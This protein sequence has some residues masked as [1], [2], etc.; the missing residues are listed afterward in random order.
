M[1]CVGVDGSGCERFGAHLPCPAPLPS[2]IRGQYIGTWL[3][4]EGF[5]GAYVVGHDFSPMSS[6]HAN[7]Q[8]QPQPQASQ[9]MLRGLLRWR[10]AFPT[11]FR[12]PPG[13]VSL[14][15]GHTHAPATPGLWAAPARCWTDGPATQVTHIHETLLAGG[16]SPGIDSKRPVVKKEGAAGP[17]GL[18]GGPPPNILPPAAEQHIATKVE[19]EDAALIFEYA[20]SNLLKKHGLTGLIFPKE[21][22]WLAG[23]PGS[24]KGTMATS[25]AAARDLPGIIEVSSLLDAEHAEKKR[26]GLLVDDRV[27]LETVL[28]KMMDDKFIDGGGVV[29]DGF[30]RTMV[31]ALTIKLLFDQMKILRDIHINDPVLKN[32]FRRPFFRIVCLYVEEEESIRRQLRRGAEVKRNNEIVRLSGLGT[33]KP[34]RDTD[35]SEEKARE[36]YKVFKT[37]VYAALKEIKPHFHFSFIKADGPPEEVIRLIKEEFTYQSS[38]DLGD[39]TFELVRGIPT[40]DQITKLSRPAMV[41][42]LNMFARDDAGLFNEIVQLIHRDFLHIISR[43]SLA[44]KAIIRSSSALLERNNA[45]NILLDVLSERGYS[46]TLEVQRISVPHLISPP[47]PDGR[48]EITCR[49][50]KSWVFT[51]KFPKPQIRRSTHSD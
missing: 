27:V 2:S 4:P 15:A 7:P 21:V 33:Y 12:I 8:L 49:I 14:T 42:R 41:Q 20:W 22:I 25:I 10:G 47:G 1:V 26:L 11:A 5:V 31:Q 19:I 37:Q 48:Q 9:Q 43:Q 24:G 35:T 40:A 51:I 18:S 36:R 3:E 16:D 29:V 50:E 44:G 30:P 34:V 46:V 6:R 38:L 13:S 45:I 39:D 17:G 23:A 32:K 28:E